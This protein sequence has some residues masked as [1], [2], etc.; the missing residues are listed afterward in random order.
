MQTAAAHQ[1][2]PTAYNGHSS[3]YLSDTKRQRRSPTF[4]C[5][6]YADGLPEV[7]MEAAAPTGED[8]ANGKRSRRTSVTGLKEAVEEA[9]QQAAKRVKAGA[10][11]LEGAPPIAPGKLA[12]C[13]AAMGAAR[14]ESYAC[15][16]AALGPG[17]VCCICL[18]GE[19]GEQQAAIR[20]HAGAQILT[21]GLQFYKS[22]GSGVLCE[23][24][25]V[26]MLQ[27]ALGAD[28]VRHMCLARVRLSHQDS[29]WFVAC[30]D[31]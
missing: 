1:W 11:S 29:W 4:L 18:A 28:T 31:A 9:E 23:G 2:P 16:R 12:C 22:C 27:T 8:V 5:L 7:E 10:G 21:G 6:V 19:Q 14:P 25:D 15:S 30:G 24:R 3:I 26:D 20:V 13:A 17:P